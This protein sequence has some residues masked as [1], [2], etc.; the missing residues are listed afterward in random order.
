MNHCR[1][2]LAWR[3]PCRA[4]VELEGQHCDDHQREN[5]A[6]CGASATG[7]CSETMGPFVCGQPICDNC[8]HTLCSNG[9]NSGGERPPGL[10]TH[11]PKSEQVF[12]VW[13]DP[14]ADEHNRATLARLRQ[15]HEG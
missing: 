4:P 10:D 11:C 2:S 5:C 6:S 15:G 14:G 9:C 1:Y 7:E 12:K 3:G 8:E 13:C